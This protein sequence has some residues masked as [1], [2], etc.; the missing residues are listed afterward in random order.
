MPLR[1]FVTS[2]GLF[3][4]TRMLPVVESV[5]NLTFSLIL[6]K[7]LGVA[8]VLIATFIA[9]LASD[10][11]IRPIIIYNKLFER[12]CKE[13]Y[14]K[15]VFFIVTIIINYIIC[16]GLFEK[17]INK[18]DNYFT[19]FFYS[20]VIFGVNFVLAVCEFYF[21]KNMLFLD[22]VKNYINRKK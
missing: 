12:S 9:Y 8:G 11:F 19:W 17:L 16:A 13:Y 1:T 18:A 6:L 4:E 15:N 3:K 20:V 10:Y 14:I 5:V 21:S 7:Y 2:A 22:R